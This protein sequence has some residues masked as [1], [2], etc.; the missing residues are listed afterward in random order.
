MVAPRAISEWAASD[1]IASEPLVTPTMAFAT[2]RP[3]DAAIEESATLC[4]TSC[5]MCLCAASGSEARRPRQC[6]DC[7]HDGNANKLHLTMFCRDA[8]DLRQRDCAATG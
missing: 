4:L 5:I 2:V 7:V 8:C 1:R 3:A 6:N